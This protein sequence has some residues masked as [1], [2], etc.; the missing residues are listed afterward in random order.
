M[1]RRRG[2]EPGD[3][4]LARARLAALHPRAGWVPRVPDPPETWPEETGP[5]E[6]WPAGTGSAESW[7]AAD[8]WFGPLPAEP[9]PDASRPSPAE[10]GEPAAAPVPD[11]RPGPGRHR[12]GG[13]T[14][15]LPVALR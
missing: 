4:E 5:K 12:V 8:A 9:G 13:V 15:R 14:D 1:P 7:P 10:P 2:Q 6:T 3:R 11:P